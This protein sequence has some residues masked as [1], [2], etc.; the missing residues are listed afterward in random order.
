MYIS[1]IPLNSARYETRRL[2]ASPYKLHA[3]VEKSF[4]PDA[5]REGAQGRILW[6]LDFS[7]D[8]NSTW[9]YVV[10]PEKPDFTHIVE[11]AGW[12]MH[13]NWEIKDYEILLSKMTRGQE[14]AFRL[15]ANPV[16]EVRVDQGRRPNPAVVGKLKGHVTVNHQL[17]WLVKR[18]VKNGFEVLRQPGDNSSLSCTVSQRR[19]E[20]FDHGA[21]KVTLT[22]AQYDGLLRILDADT[23]RRCLSHGIG[24]AKSFGCGLLT[25]APIY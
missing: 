12:P 13:P 8:G 22:T 24:R 4:P 9:L 1:R 18:S 10:S 5:V 7:A 17:D 16:R 20:R 6:R 15:R 25:V 3:A 19:T 21:S 14:W 2:I 11:Q 23:F